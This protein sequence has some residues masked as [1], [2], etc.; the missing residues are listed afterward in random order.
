MLTRKCNLSPDNQYTLRWYRDKGRG[1]EA[2]DAT[3]ANQVVDIWPMAILPCSDHQDADRRW[4]DLYRTY[5]VNA[6]LY[7]PFVRA[8]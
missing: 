1:Q 8:T 4:W 5:G 6:T 7:Y 2:A 3:S